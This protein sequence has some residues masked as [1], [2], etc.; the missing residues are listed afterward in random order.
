[1]PSTLGGRWHARRLRLCIAVPVRNPPV[2]GRGRR[3]ARGGNVTTT[4][5]SSSS[6]RVAVCRHEQRARRADPRQPAAHCQ[7]VVVCVCLGGPLTGLTSMQLLLCLLLV[8]A[9][10]AAPS[11][12]R[13]SLRGD[14]S[15]TFTGLPANSIIVDFI[16][17]VRGKHSSFRSHASPLVNRNDNRIG[18]PESSRHERGKCHLIA[19]GSTRWLVQGTS[20]PKAAG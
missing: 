3:S 2:D 14:N 10:L 15:E 12:R 7:P 17:H 9:G 8:P 18:D 19:M 6:R 11:S 4:A 13:T 16:G 20:S 5:S 1:M